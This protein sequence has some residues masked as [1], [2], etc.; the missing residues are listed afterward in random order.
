[1]AS[2]TGS[3]PVPSC[4]W[5][6]HVV[7]RLDYDISSSVTVRFS[8]SFVLCALACS[9]SVPVPRTT[10]P[11]EPDSAATHEARTSA[12]DDPASCIEPATRAQNAWLREME[13]RLI[14][15][16]ASF[17]TCTPKGAFARNER[18][19]ATLLVLPDGTV[20]GA[21]GANT[22]LHDCKAA[23]CLMNAFVAESPPDA[24]MG[25]DPQH[26]VVRV[27]LQ[28][29]GPPRSRTASDP[30][31]NASDAI[32]CEG[33]DH[34]TS[35]K[36]APD[37][38]YTVV[39]AT[40]PKFEQC[41]AQ[42]LEKSAD[43]MGTVFVRFVIRPD[44]RVDNAVIQDNTLR[45]CGVASCVRDAVAE[46]TFPAPEGGSVTVVYPVALQPAK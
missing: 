37:L 16:M 40:Y 14:Q 43:L 41:Y 36:L 24:R 31:F 34:V 30:P 42:G 17:T 45:N 5:M 3:G 11:T 32:S 35:G 12:L 6:P 33:P 19:A 28:P 22:S 13:G 44:G 39:R 9:N 27:V 8:D 46:L 38:M 18:L 25:K 29:D 21:I 7:G 15:R 4:S 26:V 2:A 23:K 20:T 10:A 1:M